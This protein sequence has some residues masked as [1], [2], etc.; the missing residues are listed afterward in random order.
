MKTL[1]FFL[2][3]ARLRI[4]YIRVSVKD[5]LV[6]SSS[7]SIAAAEAAAAFTPPVS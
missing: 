2:E 5:K 7:S 3:I 4:N 6:K 1:H